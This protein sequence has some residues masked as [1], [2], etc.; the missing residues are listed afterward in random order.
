VAQSKYWNQ[1]FRFEIPQSGAGESDR[2]VVNRCFVGGAFGLCNSIL[3]VAQSRYWNQTFHFEIPQSGA[4][5][6]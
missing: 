1:T 6:S 3:P 2:R 5:E 4:G